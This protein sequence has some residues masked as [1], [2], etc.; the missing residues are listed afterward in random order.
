MAA[1]AAAPPIEGHNNEAILREGHQPCYHSMA[2]VPRERQCLFLSM[3]FLWL[4]QT[5][6]TPPIYLQRGS[7]RNILHSCQDTWYCTLHIQMCV[8]KC[9]MS[10]FFPAGKYL[11][12][13]VQKR[14][15]ANV[16]IKAAESQLSLRTELW[17]RVLPCSLPDVRV[18]CP[19]VHASS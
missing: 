13:Q 14:H 1:R 12:G 17:F 7:D 8:T 4:N 11:T 6:Q 19:F 18:T 2:L 15:E 9:W 5:A 16:R 3:A 10:H